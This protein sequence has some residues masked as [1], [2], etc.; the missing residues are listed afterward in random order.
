ML[1][2]FVRLNKIVPVK[3]CRTLLV[4]YHY[5]LSPFI[6]LEMDNTFTSSLSTAYLQVT[7]LACRILVLNR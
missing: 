3:V 2:P 7:A 4:S 6:D 5:L 1:H